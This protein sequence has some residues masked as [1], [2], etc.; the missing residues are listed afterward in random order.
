M[1][2]AGDVDGG[3]SAGSLAGTA[4]GEQGK[5]QAPSTGH[6]LLRRCGEIVRQCLIVLAIGGVAAQEFLRETGEIEV[7][8]R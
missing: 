6:H 7:P 8:P 4:S 2:V 3:Q 1:T 5:A